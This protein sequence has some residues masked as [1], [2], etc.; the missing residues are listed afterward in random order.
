MIGLAEYPRRDSPYCF[1]IWMLPQIGRR[2]Q[3]RPSYAARRLVSLSQ[4]DSQSFL[5]LALTQHL[6]NKYEV[7]S[8]VMVVQ[9]GTVRSWCDRP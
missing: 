3:A 4:A 7:F 9:L 1:L 6:G 5:E 2:P 8:R